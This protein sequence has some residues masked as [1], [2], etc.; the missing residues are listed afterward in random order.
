MYGTA[1][2]LQSTELKTST[3]QGMG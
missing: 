3:E 2:A 1:L